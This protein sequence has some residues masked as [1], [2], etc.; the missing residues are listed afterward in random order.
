LITEIV[1]AIA[2]S[3]GWAIGRPKVIRLASLA[4]E[5]LDRLAGVYEIPGLATLTV[6]VA[7]AGLHL[8]APA[9][10]PGRYEML[11]ES[12]TRF[13]ILESGVTAVFQRGADG[14]VDT[15]AISGPLGDWRAERK[16]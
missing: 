13:S 14:A 7:P 11:P 12:E 9:V 8:H 4:P 6:T 3:Y 5:A 16:G 15:I 1:G 10:R 2:A